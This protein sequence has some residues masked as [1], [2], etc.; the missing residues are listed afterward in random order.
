MEPA[1]SSV[2]IIIYAQSRKLIKRL[3]KEDRE[4]RKIGSPHL[5][6]GIKLSLYKYEDRSS[7]PQNTHD[8]QTSVAGH[9]RISRVWD[10]VKGEGNVV[11]P[12]INVNLN[13]R[14]SFS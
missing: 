2:I 8:S 13:P 6:Q 10:R 7:D 9:V 11:Y 14:S 5:S 12:E 4:P 1:G 3:I